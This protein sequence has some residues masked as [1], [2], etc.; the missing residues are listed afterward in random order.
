MSD[1]KSQ[2]ATSS[3]VDIRAVESFIFREARLADEHEY[4]AWE[5]LWTDDATY[6]VPAGRMDEP[7]GAMSIISDNRHRIATRIKQL[8]SGRRYAQA[9]PSR[10]RRIVSNIEVM[11][12][13]EVGDVRVEANFV[14][15]EARERASHTWAGRLTYHLRSDANSTS[16]LRSDGFAMSYK[17]VDLVDREWAQPSIA[18]LI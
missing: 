8:E 16:G 5:A 9:P 17:L 12:E 18:F 3:E 15:V 13:T 4:A 14:L 1:A 7:T 6:W 2:S 10:L 11:G